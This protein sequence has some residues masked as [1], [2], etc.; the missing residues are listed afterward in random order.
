M[1]PV[2]FVE[3]HRLGSGAV[4]WLVDLDG[5]GLA[6]RGEF[7]AR[8]R[9]RYGLANEVDELWAAYRRR[10]PH[11][12]TCIPDLLGGLAELRASGWRVG[13]VTNG[14]ADNQLGKIERTGLVDV[15]DGYACSGAEGARKPDR[16]LFEI[17]GA[18]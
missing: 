4:E 12:V 8:V 15:V 14:M 7:F 9:E 18:R 6:H 17:A 5:S 13:I 1:W 2:E 16:R 3:V 10:M 11:L